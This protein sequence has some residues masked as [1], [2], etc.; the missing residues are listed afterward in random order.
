MVLSTDTTDE[1]SPKIPH[2]ELDLTTNL[3][4]LVTIDKIRLSKP[5]VLLT[6][7]G[8]VRDHA[9]ITK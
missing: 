3:M 6:V 7:R 9:M 4:Q 2:T 5:S 1:R 8:R